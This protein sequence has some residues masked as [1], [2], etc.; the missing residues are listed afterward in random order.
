MTL[1]QCVFVVLS[2]GHILFYLL[3]NWRIIALKCYIGFCHTSTCISHRYTHVPSP[4][5][6]P[7]LSNLIP[8][9]YVVTE[10][11]AEIPVLYNNFPLAIYFTYGNVFISILLS[12]F[13]P[14]A[15][16]LPVSTNLF[17]TLESL[18][19]SCKLFHQYHFSRVH[20]YVLK[21]RVKS[22]SRVQLFATP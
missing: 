20:T 16:A 9:F 10:H 15:P 4:L 21:V 12:Q 6:V 17:C 8:P 1:I 18:F 14:P 19:L 2:N 22:L 3:F 11:Q 5:N 13:V 7:P